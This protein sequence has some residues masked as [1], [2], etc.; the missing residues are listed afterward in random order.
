MSTR[1]EVVQK[2]R[3]LAFDAIRDDILP[4]DTTIQEQ[5]EGLISFA[6]SLL[7][8][9]TGP[10]EAELEGHRLVKKHRDMVRCYFG[11]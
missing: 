1:P 7:R 10:E 8:Y 4:S 11:D 2:I 9:H 3:L 6:M 5:A